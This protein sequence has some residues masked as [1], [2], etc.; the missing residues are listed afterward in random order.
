M[1]HYK[2]QLIVTYEDLNMYIVDWKF[3]HLYKETNTKN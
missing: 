1:P 3:T 2:Y